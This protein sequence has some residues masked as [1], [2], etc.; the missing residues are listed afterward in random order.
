MPRF[1]ILFHETPPG[2]ERGSHFDLMLEAGGV[3]RTWAIAAWPAPGETQP[4][5]RLPDHRLAYLD[6]EGAV[7][8]NRGHV[9]RWDAGEYYLLKESPTLI[10]AHFEGVRRQGTLEFCRP[11]D[12]QQQWQLRLV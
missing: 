12:R 6:Y 5:E 7:S 9:R 8:G 2:Y 1:V 3:L 4:A 10:L 11:D